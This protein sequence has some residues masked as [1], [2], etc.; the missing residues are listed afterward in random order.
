[1]SVQLHVLQTLAYLVH[2]GAF[3]AGAARADVARTPVARTAVANFIVLEMGLI[4]GL[5]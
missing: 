2:A 1:M 3:G 5:F 4:I